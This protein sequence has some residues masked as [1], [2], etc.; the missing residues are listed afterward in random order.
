M[1]CS[2]VVNS[3]KLNIWKEINDQLLNFIKEVMITMKQNN[4]NNKYILNYLKIEYM[5]L[6][7][8]H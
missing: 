7:K 1:L 3:F 5:C 4:K 8:R 6:F 2:N